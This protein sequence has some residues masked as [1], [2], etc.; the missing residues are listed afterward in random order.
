[1]KNDISCVINSLQ[2]AY[3]DATIRGYK[4]DVSDYVDWCCGHGYQSFPA[5]PKALSQYL[6]S[7]AGKG[8]NPRTLERRLY[9]IRKF[10]GLMEMS[11]PTKASDVQLTF[12]R[13]KRA[14][15]A[16]PQ[17]AAAL[18]RDHLDRILDGEPESPTDLR[19]RLI[20][21]LGFDLLARRSEIV[22][23]RDDDCSPAPGGAYSFLIRRSKADPF[24][25]GRI[26]FCSPRSARLLE[27]WW[28][29]R[30]TETSWLFCPIY[31]DKSV[32]R[33][34]S[35][36]TVRRTVKQ[37]MIELG[38]SN[39]EARRFSGH[40]MRVGAA[41]DLL[42]RGQDTAGIMRAGGWKSIKVLSR[43]LETAEHNPW[44]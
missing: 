33:A 38:K 29:W 22:A 24:G 14:S 39:D 3:A 15:H 6:D 20:I 28:E 41:Q 21:A 9:A 13:I 36:T 40:S 5:E 34:L 19:N 30:G 44:L 12:R 23:L 26:A 27:A 16:R 25:A 43:Y 31:N 18:T 42:K 4:T 2:G 17:Q 1:M 32:D 11:D 35:G 8:L 7:L 37:A 10:H